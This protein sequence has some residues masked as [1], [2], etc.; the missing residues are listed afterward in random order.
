MQTAKQVIKYFNIFV[1]TEQTI[2]NCSVGPSVLQ[3]ENRSAMFFVSMT[4]ID[5]V[6]HEQHYF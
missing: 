4:Q 5:R 3:K 2:L 6:S 1:V